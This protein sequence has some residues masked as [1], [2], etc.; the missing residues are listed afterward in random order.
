MRVKRFD[1]GLE[2]ISRW[3]VE[4]EQH[5]PKTGRL[6]PKFLPRAQALDEILARPTLEERLPNMLEPTLSDPDLLEPTVMTE[7]RNGAR[8]VF[9][10]VALQAEGPRREALRKAAVI[11]DEEVGFDDEIRRALAELLKG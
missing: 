1:S 8:D 4:D 3:Q 11:L 10:R 5:L 9:Q 6:A 2:S 7:A